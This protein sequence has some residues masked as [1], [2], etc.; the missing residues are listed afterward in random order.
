MRPPRAKLP[1]LDY[2]GQTTEELIACKAD[3]RID[4]L[5]CAFEA[6]IQAK[7]GDGAITSEEEL[8]L[9]VMALE[10]EVNNGG[11]H[12]FFVNSSRQVAPIIVDCLRR[13][14]CFATAAITERAIEALRLPELTVEAIAATIYTENA[15]RDKLLEA[16]DQEYYRLSEITPK[17]FG[18]VEA[19]QSRIQLAKASLPPP[20]RPAKRSN[21][22]KL[23]VHLRCAKSTDHSLDAV[24][25]LARELAVR[26]SIP[27][28]EGEIEGAAVL[29]AFRCAVDA[30]DLAACELLAPR[31]FELMR[32]DT[33]HCVHHRD[34]AEK[35]IGASKHEAADAATLV[36]LEY[37]QGCDQSALGT[38]N[39]ILFWAALLQNHRAALPRAVEF[40]V[41]NFPD[42]DLD[43][44]LPA[45]RFTAKER[46]PR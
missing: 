42:E 19:Q 41:A 25:Q 35:L 4:S 27:A 8:V 33:L 34:W 3:H 37:L 26:D 32:E 17:L 11:H 14:E 23:Y 38:Q 29:Y 22:S 44:R 18:F 31:A 9:A 20:R 1:W 24:R 45:Q 6:G 21:T 5:L 7:R 2:T 13:I 43:Q 46:T 36:Y 16:C 30:G 10:R 28:T 39:R 40:F 15:E 12:Q